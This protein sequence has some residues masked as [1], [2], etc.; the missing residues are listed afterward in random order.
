MQVGQTHGPARRH[1]TKLFSA[2]PHVRPPGPYPSC[3]CVDE[4]QAGRKQRT[5][6]LHHELQNISCDAWLRLCDCIERAI[7][8]GQP[9][10]APLDELSGAERAD[11]ITLPA[12]IG[13]LVDVQRLGL[14]G[15]HLVRLPPE[16]GGMRSLAY[17]DVYTSYRLHFLPYEATHCVNLRDSRVSTRALFGNYKHRPTFPDLTHLDNA[18]A[19]A[20]LA[21]SACS[22]CGSALDGWIVTRWITLAVGTDWVPLLVNACSMACIDALPT[23]ADAY[24]QHPHTG[25]AKV[26][27][28]PAKY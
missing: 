6:A 8:T 7:A 13:R 12:S 17:L 26:L 18:E 15:S 4:G 5:P 19:L 22:V 16:I 14:Y 10:F 27:Q 20:L 21:P 9:E 1:V 2:D 23:P 24:V 28:P 25:G 11:I 3:A